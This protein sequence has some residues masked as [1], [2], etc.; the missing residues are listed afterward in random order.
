VGLFKAVGKLFSYQQPAPLT[1]EKKR[2]FELMGKSNKDLNILLGRRPPLH[3]KKQTLVDMVI[4]QEFYK[5][6]DF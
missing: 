3:C 1:E 5:K 2:R 6:Q 4:Y